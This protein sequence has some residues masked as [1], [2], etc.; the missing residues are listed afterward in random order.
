MRKSVNKV[1][2]A[3]ATGI[4]GVRYPGVNYESMDA[5][6]DLKECATIKSEDNGSEVN[7]SI[8][9][10]RVKVNHKP[11]GGNHEESPPVF[12]A[13]QF[14]ASPLLKRYPQA[15]VEFDAGP[16]GY[17]VFAKIN[18]KKRTV[19]INLYSNAE[20]DCRGTIDADDGTL[21]VPPPEEADANGR[22]KKKVKKKK[23]KAKG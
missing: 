17:A 23:E 9:M 5:A 20:A 8:T 4:G 15:H 13:Y 3:F 10:N 18:L 6:H 16:N 12:P 2:N 19:S 14:T 1:L 21:H 7:I 11:D 22:P